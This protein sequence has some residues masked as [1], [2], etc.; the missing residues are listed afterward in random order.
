MS[1]PIYNTT[2]IPQCMYASHNTSVDAGQAECRDDADDLQV[3]LDEV[4]RDCIKNENMFK[5]MLN[6]R[7]LGVGGDDGENKKLMDSGANRGITK[8]AHLLHGYRRIKKIPVSDISANGAACYIV[9]AGYMDIEITDGEYITC[10]M[11]HAPN[12]STTVIPTL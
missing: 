4:M 6:V 12:S 10:K 5:T 9:G 7:L 8:H 1:A 11:Y 3:D 2:P